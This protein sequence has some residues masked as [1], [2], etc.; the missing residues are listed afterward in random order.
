M[1]NMSV[2]QDSTPSPRPRGRPRAFD[3]VEALAV[4]M[5]LFWRRGYTATAISDLTEAMGIGTKSLYAAFGSKEQLFEEA[6]AHYSACYDRNI[7]GRF[8][9]APRVREAVEAL[10]TDSAAVLTKSC[11][12]GDP[13]GCMVT[14]INVEGE[15]NPQLTALVHGARQRNLSRVKDRMLKAKEDGELAEGVD[16]GIFA[17]M[18]VTMQNG[19]SLQARNGASE[20]ELLAAVRLT[21]AGWD[22]WLRR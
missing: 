4:A 3:R 17:R 9:A 1:H 7:W 18:V 20:A 11:G 19:M 22:G 10:L 14:L 15:D 5:R 13:L 2:A 6:F 21:L 8:D 16:A 12:N